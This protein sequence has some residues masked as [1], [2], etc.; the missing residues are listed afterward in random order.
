MRDQDSVFKSKTAAAM[1]APAA[2]AQESQ[3]SWRQ[4]PS[5][6]DRVILQSILSVHLYG[7]TEAG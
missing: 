4:H 2:A 7:G 3:N 5:S 1:V 6:T